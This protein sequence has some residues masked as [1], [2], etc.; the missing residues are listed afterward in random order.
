MMMSKEQLIEEIYGRF[1]NCKFWDKED[2]TC[3]LTVDNS[4]RCMGLNKDN[5]KLRKLWLDIGGL[6]EIIIKEILEQEKILNDFIEACKEK[7]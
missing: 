2:S 3:L 1:P 6:G 7:L 4:I 5:C